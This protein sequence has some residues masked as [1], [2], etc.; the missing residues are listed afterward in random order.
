MKR[1]DVKKDEGHPNEITVKERELYTPSLP[2]LPL[3]HPLP[4]TPP[5]SKSYLFIFLFLG[6]AVVLAMV[7]TWY[8]KS[9][10]K[11]TVFQPTTIIPYHIR[12][13][14]CLE[15]TP[16]EILALQYDPSWQQ[17]RDSLVYWMQNLTRMEAITAFHVGNPYCYIM[18]RQPDKSLL[19]LFNL[20]F[21]GYY[22]NNIVSRNEVSLSC[23]DL[24]KNVDRAN[25][26]YVEYLDDHDGQLVLRKFNHT[27]AFVL[28]TTGFY[29]KG[30]STCDDSDKGVKT[31]EQF[32]K[33]PQY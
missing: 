21:M 32:I 28:Q 17:A 22:K 2:P 30:L 24:V 19:G 29:L 26:L 5:P 11:E 6:L 14:G 8:L 4:P 18:I 9:L 31:L 10:P 23:K 3:P 1:K 16:E 7:G 15:V 33:H 13:T 27:Q 12:K 20:K 25:T